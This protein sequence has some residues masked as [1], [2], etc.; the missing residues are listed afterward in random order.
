MLFRSVIAFDIHAKKGAANQKTTRLHCVL[1]YVEADGTTDKTTIASSA[2]TTEVTDTETIYHIH[3]S[4]PESV[5]IDI[6]DRII[7]DVYANVGTGAQDSV[8]T[9]YMEGV[10]DSH[11]DFEVSGGIWQNYGDVLDDLNTL[12][13]VGADSEVLVGTA[14][15]ALAWESGAT[16]RT[17]FR[18]GYR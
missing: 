9:L 15:G 4:L 18:S 5:E 2:I 3:A 8:V 6:T 10:H 14:A 16:L 1:S 7:L 17:S 12:G 13:A 11:V